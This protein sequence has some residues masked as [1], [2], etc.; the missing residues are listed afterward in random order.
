MSQA[1]SRHP[2]LLW[3]LG[4]VAL[5]LL[6]WLVDA[7]EGF[8][9]QTE[10]L[11]GLSRYPSILITL[12]LYAA[13]AFFIDQGLRIFVWQDAYTRLTG[14]AAPGVIQGAA[15]VAVYSIAALVVLSRILHLDTGAVLISTGVVAGVLGVAMQNTIADLFS[16]VALG[17]DQPYRIGDW[18][19]FDDGTLGEVVDITWRSTRIRSW[20]ASL[21]VVPNKR[22]ATSTV[23]NYQRPNRTYAYWFEVAVSCEVSPHLVR[24]LLLKAA[25]SCRRV[26][27]DPAPLVYF[28][29][30]G[31]PFRYMVFVHFPDYPW[32]YA[33]MDE[34]SLAIH[35]QFRQAGI[36]PAAVTY[37]IDAR[38][39]ESPVAALPSVTEVLRNVAVFTP[40]S[41]DEIASLAEGLTP[42][43]V[44]VGERIV[45]QGESGDSMFVIATGIVVLSRAL[46]G[47]VKEIERLGTGQ[48]FGELSLLTG[49]PRYSTARTATNVRLIEIP[50]AQF[51]PLLAGNAELQ[52]R[53]AEIAAARRA[54]SEALARALAEPA[55]RGVLGAEAAWLKQLIGNFFAQH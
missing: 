3:L 46:E 18:V 27:R 5:P 23:H 14:T 13:V 43:E 36:A 49:E 34:L 45:E 8:L 28:C 51:A 39:A 16:G 10:A 32:R 12:L 2:K 1:R 22:A 31:R 17:I 38:R 30:P 9:A 26:L 42:R 55:H 4:L 41:D 54:Q 35:E 44:G 19:E 53:L 24:E 29:D 52:E 40:L 21:Y 7:L 6:L 37:Q 20:N 33:A 25:L 11:D 50:K 47:Q 48:C 15:S